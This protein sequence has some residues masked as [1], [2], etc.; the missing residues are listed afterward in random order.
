MENS[1]FKFR[2]WDS[3]LKFM[4][5]QG[6]YY[7]RF[8]GSVWYDNDDRNLYLQSSKLKV[9]QYSGLKDRYGVEIY[10]GDIIS[11]SYGIPPVGV[12]APIEFHEGCFFAVTKRH[13][14]P[15]CPIGELKSCVGDFE[16]IGNIYENPEL[17]NN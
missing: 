12:R 6:C 11:F 1:R 15:R 16:V 7:V 9:M 5:E 13:S 10:E 17:L 8:D 3:E 4:V 14:P 2:A